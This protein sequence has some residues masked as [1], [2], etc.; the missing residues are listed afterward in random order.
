MAKKVSRHSGL[1]I[2]YI[3]FLMVLRGVFGVVEIINEL[4]QI[5]EL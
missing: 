5:L 2:F 3:S 1:V 4:K